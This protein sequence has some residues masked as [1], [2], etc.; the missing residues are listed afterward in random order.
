MIHGCD[1]KAVPISRCEGGLMDDS[2]AFLG[3][4]LLIVHFLVLIWAIAN[5]HAWWAIGIFL[6]PLVGDIVYV[7]YYFS[8]REGADPAP[9]PADFRPGQT[10]VV[11][12]NALW[13]Q[14]AVFLR[15]G[16]KGLLTHVEPVTW[17]V[18]VR[19]PDGLAI[20][21]Y[22]T[23]DFYIDRNVPL[24]DDLDERR[25]TR[26]QDDRHSAAPAATQSDLRNQLEEL[27]SLRDDGLISDEE[28]SAK[29]R[30]ILG[31]DR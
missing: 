25:P 18:T 28:F 4:I 3:V 1:E 9:P 27:R 24:K 29:K 14:G 10:V 7:I 23:R 21:G 26:S 30:Q 20:T 12:K 5:R 16:E 13:H 6:F 8:S 17:T 31:L 11:R 22:Q 19:R 15:K 2:G